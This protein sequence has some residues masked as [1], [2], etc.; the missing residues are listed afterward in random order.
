MDHQNSFSKPK[1]KEISLKSTKS[2]ISH[3]ENIVQ[4][5]FSGA[6]SMKIVLG[7][8]E[9]VVNDYIAIRNHQNGLHSSLS[10]QTRI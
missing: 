9:S 1:F 4:D 10:T 2:V 7:I 3:I 5:A 8:N 6:I